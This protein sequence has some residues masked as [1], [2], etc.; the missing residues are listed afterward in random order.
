MDVNN[1]VLQP[2]QRRRVMRGNNE[3]YRESVGKMAFSF[4]NKRT[5]AIQH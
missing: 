5:G 1:T 2:G 3:A 4:V